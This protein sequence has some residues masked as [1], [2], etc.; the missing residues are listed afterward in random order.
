MRIISKLKEI[1]K[2]KNNN[3]L[4]SVHFEEKITNEE[5]QPKNPKENMIN[6]EIQLVNLEEL[7]SL[8][9]EELL[10]I[11][12]NLSQNE[13]TIILKNDII[14]NKLKNYILE[15]CKKDTKQYIK[16][17]KDKLT[18]VE[19]IS[20][21]DVP[22]I[23]KTYYNDDLE[24]YKLFRELSSNEEETKEIISYLL[25]NKE[26]FL[27]YMRIIHLINN[28]IK[29]FDYNTNKNILNKLY[30]YNAK[31]YL[32]HYVTYIPTGE[33]IKLVSNNIADEILIKIIYNLS[34]DTLNYLFKTDSRM[35]HIL[36][37]LKPEKLINP[38]ILYPKN[39]L[40]NPKFFDILKNESFIVF[41]NNINLIEKHNLPEPIER[42]LKLYYQEL[43]DS[44]NPDNGLFTQYEEIINNLKRCGILF[45]ERTYILDRN[46]EKIYVDYLKNKELNVT[47]EYQQLTSYKL[48][49]IV[50]DALFQDNIYNVFLNI[51]EMIR[52]NYKLPLNEQI[53]DE[54]KL[55]FYN[56]IL[57]ID[58]IS[59]EEKVKLY[60]NLKDKNINLMFY[61][62]LRKL[63]DKSY[64]IINNQIFKLGNHS[65]NNILTK[66]YK[67]PIYNM[68]D[69]EFFM[70]VRSEDTH[71]TTTETKRNCYSIISN[72]NSVTYGLGSLTIYG[73]NV[74]DI[75]KVLHIYE[76]DAYS[77]DLDDNNA[78]QKNVINRIMTPEEIVNGSSWYSE[79]QIIN[80]KSP[81]NEEIYLAKNPDYIVVYNE[82]SYY[83]IAESKRLNIPIVIINEKKLEKDKLIE[84]EPNKE[85]EEIVYVNNRGSEA[86]VKSKLR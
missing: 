83:D 12:S 30:E 14:K 9:C 69:Q 40:N 48:S 52:Y 59:S 61:E 86:I 10:N 42:N 66:K 23:K 72:D 46:S 7:N 53:L 33:Q 84:I 51:K 55:N 31:Y 50:V 82:P 13:K 73:Y 2:T 3:E 60:N 45:G 57:N 56:L 38:N 78:Y 4:P 15:K 74:L 63:K 17:I 20:L 39:I 41:R 34:D 21:L 68:E 47:N 32:Y 75:D 81:E 16:I 6:S 26:M 85:K 67:V 43:I 1:F 58:H 22:S 5:I 76:K 65:P 36:Y 29:Y 44:Y 62:D 24:E 19:I 8:D 25:N 49:E 77:A 27:E 79:I 18:V 70:L 71:Q 54:K 28:V 11:I 35:E 80:S 64:E 37:N